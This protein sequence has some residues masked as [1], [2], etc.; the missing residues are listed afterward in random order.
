MRPVVEERMAAL[1]R[2]ACVHAYVCVCVRACVCVC[3]LDALLHRKEDE[4][5][6][7][8][9]KFEEALAMYRK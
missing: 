1:Q 4:M 9:Q 6:T 3:H 2:C 5:K 7:I 8:N